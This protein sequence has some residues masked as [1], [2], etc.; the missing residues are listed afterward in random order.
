MQSFRCKLLHENIKYFTLFNQNYLYMCFWICG[1]HR[2]V[3]VIHTLL[4]VYFFSHY[5]YT[6]PHVLQKLHMLN[7]FKKTV[8]L[9]IYF[10]CSVFQW[11]YR[12]CLRCYTIYIISMIQYNYFSNKEIMPCILHIYKLNQAVLELATYELYETM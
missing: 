12:R 8:I 4:I 3:C 1:I 2:V 7:L 10:K 5:N 11:K 9:Q 6:I